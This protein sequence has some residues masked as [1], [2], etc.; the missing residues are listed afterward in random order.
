MCVSMCAAAGKVITVQTKRNGEFLQM[1]EAP[2][3]LSSQPAL[4]KKHMGWWWKGKGVMIVHIV[5]VYLHT[6]AAAKVAKHNH[7]H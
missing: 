3:R 5:N 4:K 1:K 2:S 6:R 7:G